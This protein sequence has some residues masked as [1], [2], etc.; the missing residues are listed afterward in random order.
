MSFNL[1]F[2]KAGV[3]APSS[4][5]IKNELNT[6]FQKVFGAKVNLDDATPQGQLIVSLTQMIVSKNAQLLYMINMMNPNYAMNDEFGNLWQDAIGALYNIERKPATPT[7]VICQC[8]GIAGTVLNGKNTN[9]PAKARAVDGSIFVCSTTVTIPET[10]V[11]ACQFEAEKTG[12]IQ[13][14]AG[15]VN[16]IYTQVVGWDTV[17]NPANGITGTETETR[18]EFEAR[19]VASLALNA[20]GSADSVYSKIASLNGVSDILVRENVTDNNK[21]IQNYTLSPHSIFVCVNGG[22]GNEIADAIFKKKSAGCDTNGTTSI[23]VVSPITGSVYNYKFE[24]P[25]VVD[26]A[27]KVVY[28]KT[29]ETPVNI[30]DLIKEAVVDNAQGLTDQNTRLKIAQTLY[31]SRFYCPLNKLSANII[32]IQVGKVGGTLGNNVDFNLNQIGSISLENVTVEENA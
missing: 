21:T 3:T 9:N 4:E 23:Q 26:C 30:E 27:V 8:T 15:A 2:S 5:E 32:D 18:E 11:I 20:T 22:D 28:E 19:R 10:G 1:I 12:K 6:L 31:A 14:G 13:I 25:S 7:T 24:R 17:N 16:K 29:T